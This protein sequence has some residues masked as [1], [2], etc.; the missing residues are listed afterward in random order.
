[1]V[2]CYGSPKK[3]VQELSFQNQFK[4]WILRFQKHNKYW[5][6]KGERKLYVDNLDKVDYLSVSRQTEWLNSLPKII[7]HNREWVS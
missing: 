6:V 1:M 3:L 2:I 4:L 7:V 5:T